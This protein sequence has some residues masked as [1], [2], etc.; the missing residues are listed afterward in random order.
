MRMSKTGNRHCNKELFDRGNLLYRERT[1]ISDEAAHTPYR[2]QRK[3]AATA[4]RAEVGRHHHHPADFGQKTR[5]IGF[6]SA[7]K[8]C[9]ALRKTFANLQLH[10]FR[11]IFPL[12]ARF[13]PVHEIFHIEI[14]LE[15]QMSRSSVTRKID[16]FCTRIN[17]Q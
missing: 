6:A 10:S 2:Q 3:N 13:L 7:K 14:N 16:K 12:S 9:Y 4:C 5:E 8:R 1:S 17:K 15:I 11:A